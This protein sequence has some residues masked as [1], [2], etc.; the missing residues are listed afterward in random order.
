MPSSKTKRSSRVLITL[1]VIGLLFIAIHFASIAVLHR[2][3]EDQLHPALPKGTSIGK[4]ELGLL[5][6]LL[7][8]SDFELKNDDEVRLAA[9]TMLV[10]IGT[11]R[12][13]FGEVQIE[14]VDLVDAYIRVD[15]REDGSFDLGLP[16]FG[17]PGATEPAAEPSA[18]LN[19]TL[20]RARMENVRIDYRDG[21]NKSDLVVDR[22]N[23]GTYSLSKIDQLVPVSWK[24]TWEGHVIA[25]DAEVA[26]DADQVRS[27]SGRLKTDLIDLSRVNLLARA[28][29]PVTG[30]VGY[31]G[32]FAWQPDKAVLTGGLKAPSFAFNLAERRIQATNLAIPEFTLEAVLEPELLVTFTPAGDA[33]VEIYDSEMD[34]HAVSGRDIAIS[35]QLRYA[36]E[37][38]LELQNADYRFRELGWQEAGRKLAISKLRIAGTVQQSLKGDTPFPAL[39]ANVSIASTAFTDSTAGLAVKLADIRLEPVSLSQLNEQ[40]AR[41]LGGRLRVGASSVEQGETVLDWQAID[42]RLGGQVGSD[43][44]RIASDLDMSALRL[45]HPQLGDAPLALDAIRITGLKHADQTRFDALRV[46]GLELPSDPAETGLK[47]ASIALGQGVYSDTA[48]VDLESIVIDGLQTAVIRDKAGQWR[49]V[50]SRPGSGEAP[51]AT[52]TAT[53][54]PSTGAGE[55][56]GLPWRVGSIRIAGDSY[57]SVSD[58]LNPDAMSPRFK[59]EKFDIGTIASTAPDNDTPFDIVLRPDQYSEFVFKGDTRPLSDLYLKAE[60]HIHGFAMKAFNGLIANDLGHRFLEGQVDNDFT[61]SIDKQKLDMGNALA[62]STVQAEAIEGKEGPPLAM[63]IALLED[64]DGNIKLDVP[65]TGDLGDPEFRVLGA[66]N[67]IIMKAVAGTA[68]LAIQ[69]LG[70]VL[71]VGTLVADQALKVT[72]EPVLFEP[73]QTGLNAAADKYLGELAK[74][75]KE[76]PKL[77][78]RFCGVAVEAE[79]KK[80]KDGKYLDKEDDMLALANQRADAVKAYLG[81]QGVGKKQLRLCRPAFDAKAEAQPRVDIKF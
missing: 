54:E 42:A 29:Q 44:L 16:P 79:R 41:D 45:A 18:P 77:G 31:D 27:A 57:L 19:L 3:V 67:P 52:A 30:E 68:A 33:T 23:V 62:M 6:G 12:L 58:Q 17:D 38:V 51:A 11:W 64:R 46:E 37:G 69:P 60:G 21:D 39:D 50:T 22:M 75:L 20:I 24:M 9:G 26:M 25:G 65:V 55:D 5:S 48:G 43:V 59:I 72:F 2:V 63:A 70:S 56:K 28:G 73:G 61:I 35:G 4:V 80:D 10:D 7:E 40:Q 53:P 13:L 76:K 36:G 8:I 34:G 15:R 47:I 81:K 1:A 66:L 32:R 71:L 14:R 78:L 49:Y 74:K